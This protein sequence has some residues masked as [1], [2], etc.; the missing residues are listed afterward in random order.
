MSTQEV[1]LT[2]KQFFSKE[3][4]KSKFTEIL[5]K[6]APAF[7][8]SVLQ[9]VSNDKNLV[10][11]DPIS[12][13]NAAATA[14]VLDLPFNNSLGF[15]WIVPFKGKAQFQVGFKGY[16][17][18][19]Q[20]SGQYARM[21]A[22][23]IFENQF[24]SYNAMTEDLDADLSIEG[25][26]RT[27]GYFAYFRLL[28]GFEKRVYWP[29]AKVTAHAQRFSKSFASE[30]SSPWKTDFDKMATKTVLKNT[31]A[32]WGP[33]SIEM[34]TAVRVDQAVI[35]SDDTIDVDYVDNSDDTPEEK[36]GKL[37]KEAEAA[38]KK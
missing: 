30:Y 17:Q 38:L 5:G 4:V 25:T 34:Q 27:V 22:G 15:A 21:N 36:A 29:I 20:R 33:M 37:A 14:A 3:S 18:L 23:P 11:V 19:A 24:K 31:I 16:V 10:N 35:N 1:A 6:K 2:T 9:L 26:G 32:P 28:N 12:I 7:I 13:Y 8:S